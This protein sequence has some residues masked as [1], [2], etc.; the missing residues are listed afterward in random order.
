MEQ[1]QFDVIA[2]KVYFSFKTAFAIFSL[3][4]RSV[5]KILDT[6]FCKKTL[7]RCYRQGCLGHV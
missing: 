5:D 6:H 1:F 3:E 2:L 7:K 4:K